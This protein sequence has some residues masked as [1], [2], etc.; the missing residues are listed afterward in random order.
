MP[1][2]QKNILT[3]DASDSYVQS[4]RSDKDEDVE[5]ISN[6]RGTLMILYQSFWPIIG[7][8]LHPSYMTVNAVLMG[9]QEVDPVYCPD[10]LSV[11]EKL[12]TT[13]CAGSKDYLAAFGMGSATVSII[14]FASAW[15]YS[16]G[17]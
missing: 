15:S 3:M 2:I 9:Q 4:H 16:A 7:N 5:E 10:S 17:L 11:D 6:C 1:V 14:I 12:A 13:Y 8:L